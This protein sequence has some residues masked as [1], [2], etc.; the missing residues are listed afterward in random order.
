MSLDIAGKWL[1]N[2][3][4]PEIVRESMETGRASVKKKKKKG[5]RENEVT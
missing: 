4:A 2:R 5:P 3:Q 1:T